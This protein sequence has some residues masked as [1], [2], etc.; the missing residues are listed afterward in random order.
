MGPGQP[1]AQYTSQYGMMPQRH[2]NPMAMGQGQGPGP[3]GPGPGPMKNMAAMYQRRNAA[4]PYP[5]PQQ[6]MQSKRQ[7][8]QYPNGAHSAQVGWSN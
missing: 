3:G 7:P 5:N 4:A 6:M 8:S 2:P 1:P